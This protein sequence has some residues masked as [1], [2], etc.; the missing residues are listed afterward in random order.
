MRLYQK[1]DEVPGEETKQ[2][3]LSDWKNKQANIYQLKCATVVKLVE[4]IK[5]GEHAIF[6]ISQEFIDENTDQD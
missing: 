3:T 2:T 4:S 5:R 1:A 6:Q